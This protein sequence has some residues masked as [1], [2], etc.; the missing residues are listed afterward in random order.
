MAEINENEKQRIEE[1]FNTVGAWLAGKMPPSKDSKAHIGRSKD[2]RVRNRHLQ[3]SQII[4]EFEK[5]KKTRQ[6]L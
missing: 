3:R 5:R 6:Q 2:D 4:E 1:G